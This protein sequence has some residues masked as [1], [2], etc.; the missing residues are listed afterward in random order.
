MKGAYIPFLLFGSPAFATT[1]EN[2][3]EFDMVVRSSSGL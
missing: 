3:A 2:H 1:S